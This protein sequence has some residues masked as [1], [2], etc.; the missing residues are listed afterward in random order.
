MKYYIDFQHLPA[1]A[2]RPIDAGQTIPI[3]ADDKEGMVILPQVGDYV[4]IQFAHGPDGFSGK[5]RSRLFNYIADGR[6]EKPIE[7]VCT[8]NIVVEDT[9]EDWGKLIKE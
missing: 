2:A 6:E 7:T 1:G 5:V 4:S 8:V 9:D 3:E